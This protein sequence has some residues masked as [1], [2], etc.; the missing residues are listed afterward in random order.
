M[1]KK[2]DKLSVKKEFEAIESDMRKKV[3]AVLA[4]KGC[5][6]KT[7][8]SGKA[9][10]K[11]LEAIDDATGEQIFAELYNM[12]NKALQYVQ[13]YRMYA[14]KIPEL[15]AQVEML[16]AEVKKLTNQR[17]DLLMIPNKTIRNATELYSS[18][19]GTYAAR[20]NNDADTAKEITIA[21]LQSCN[22]PESAISEVESTVHSLT[23]KYAQSESD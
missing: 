7:S 17:N 11:L 6:V 14:E 10:S 15:I 3:K 2:L 22:A 23:Q 1:D 4:A 21:Y 8:A 12:R 5:A 9:L 13:A 16:R 18:I 20:M 19:A